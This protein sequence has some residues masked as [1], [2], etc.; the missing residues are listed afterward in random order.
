MSGPA[1]GDR[2]GAGGAKRE[3]RERVLERVRAM[4]ASARSRESGRICAALLELLDTAWTEGAV[5]VFLA[6]DGEPDLGA[7]ASGLRLQGRV[8]CAPRVGWEDRSMTPRALTG[9]PGEIEIRRHGVPEPTA[10]CAEVALDSIGVVITPGVAFD[11][12]FARLGRGAGF[13]DRFLAAWRRSR[14]GRNVACGVGFTC[15]LVHLVPTEAHDALLD[16]LVTP[17]GVIVAH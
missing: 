9:A 3:I 17:V 14:A 5:M 13:Y 2:S 4:D 16:A 11:R 6:A 10:S 12:G 1:S 15:Q 7:V 8:V